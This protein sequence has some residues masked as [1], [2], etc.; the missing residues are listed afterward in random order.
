MQMYADSD[1][2]RATSS[3]APKR[4]ASSVYVVGTSEKM[5]FQQSS[6]VSA[7]SLVMANLSP[8]VNFE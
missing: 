2:A 6:G 1:S 7:E 5:R 4:C 3:H 8:S